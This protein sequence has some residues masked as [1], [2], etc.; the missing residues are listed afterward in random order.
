MIQLHHEIKHNL[1]TTEHIKLLPRNYQRR[2]ARAA[3]A[4]YLRRVM[5]TFLYI[6]VL[7][8]NSLESLL[9]DI[10]ISHDKCRYLLGI[11]LN[12]RLETETTPYFLICAH[13]IL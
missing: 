5:M 12:Q 3:S 11:N 7:T 8:V 1:E 6:R 10:R 2:A 13:E 4:L 9:L